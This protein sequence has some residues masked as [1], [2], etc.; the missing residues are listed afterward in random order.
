MP[1]LTRPDG[2]EIAWREQGQ[3]PP[4][5]LANMGYA[6]AVLFGGL[7]GRARARPSRPDL[8][9]PWHRRIL[10][11]RSVRHRHGRRGPSRRRR[12][13]RRGGGGGRWQRR[14]RQP[15]SEGRGRAPGPDR[16]GGRGRATSRCRPRPAGPRASSGSGSV[17]T[18]LVTLLENDYRAGVNAF[19]T[20]GNP[21]LD[22]GAVHERVELIVGHGEPGVG[23][24]PHPGLDRRTTPPRRPR[25]SDDR[26]CAPPPRD[27]PVVR[28]NE[29]RRG[30][31][32]GGATTGPSPT[33]R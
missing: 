32:P 21:D 10:A 15:R 29:A 26:L 25:R 31:P 30:A 6:P 13:R 4:V 1:T 22:E 9:H 2:A 27:Q 14:R 3:G 28:G 12:G 7:V 33:G 19:V 23:G 17:L 18:A 24:R 8:R 20:S 16:H 5:V 11:D